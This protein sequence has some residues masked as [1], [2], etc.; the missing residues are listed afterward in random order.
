[1]TRT[2]APGRS[3]GKKLANFYVVLGQLKHPKLVNMPN[4]HVEGWN[5]HVCVAIHCNATQQRTR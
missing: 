3:D 4:M 5:M 1:M 2:G